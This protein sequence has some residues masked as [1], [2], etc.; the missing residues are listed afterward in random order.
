MD[1]V[2]AT[3]EIRRLEA[4]RGGPRT[5][6]FAVTANVMND[7]VAEYLAAGID[8]HVAKPVAI[9]K[10]LAALTSAPASVRAA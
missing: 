10:L 4:E 3:R 8:G 1:G 7:Q 6:I 2:A 9:D 5:P